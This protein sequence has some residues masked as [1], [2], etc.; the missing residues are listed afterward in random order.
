MRSNDKAYTR[1]SLFIQLLFNKP[2][3][4]QVKALSHVR[5]TE[6]EIIFSQK[7]LG[8]LALL[9]SKVA[10]SSN[11]LGFLDEDMGPTFKKQVWYNSKTK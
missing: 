11:I 1:H 9:M 10:F 4:Y 7:K 3:L 2:L 8:M 6:K 5:E